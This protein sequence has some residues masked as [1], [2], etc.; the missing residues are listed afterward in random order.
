[1]KY[2]KNPWYIVYHGPNFVSLNKQYKKGVT[3]SKLKLKKSG[4]NY[5]YDYDSIISSPDNTDWLIKHNKDF[6][7]SDSAFN[8][9]SNT[10]IISENTYELIK[11]VFE[12][13][14]I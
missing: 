6:I 11:W 13:L 9:G 5:L 1:M 12:D 4:K 7:P 3:I 8:G 10:H 14:K 2:F